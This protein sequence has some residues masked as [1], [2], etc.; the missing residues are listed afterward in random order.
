MIP[1]LIFIAALEVVVLCRHKWFIALP[2]AAILF[3]TNLLHLPWNPSA[4]HCTV[5]QMVQELSDARLTASQRVIDWINDNVEP[6][7]SIWVMPNEMTYTLM[8]HAP[9]AVYAWQLKWPPEEQFK[10][11]SWIHFL[12][13]V[14]PDF[15]LSFGPQAAVLDVINQYRTKANI[16]Y[17]PA[18]HVDIYYEEATRPE[19]MWRSFKPVTGY[20][21]GAQ[22]IFIWRRPGAKQKL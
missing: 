14:P 3:G 10:Q 5:Y 8:Y 4:W 17:A 15:I 7:E 16:V 19:L 22:A 13:Q 9:Q 11:L 20:N 21:P 18:S 2:V 1:L 6:G 12:G